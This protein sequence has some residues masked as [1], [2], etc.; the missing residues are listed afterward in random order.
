MAK[1]KTANKKVMPEIA[2]NTS[3]WRMNG[4]DFL[5]LKNSMFFSCLVRRASVRATGCY[6]LAGDC[7]ALLDLCQLTLP[8]DSFATFFLPP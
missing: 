3:A 6:A 4:I 8:I 7:P 5:I 2:L 1:K